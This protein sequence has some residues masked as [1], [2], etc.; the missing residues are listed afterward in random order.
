MGPPEKIK[1]PI[2]NW[3]GL[4]GESLGS[5][6]SLRL[7]SIHK[8]RAPIPCMGTNALHFGTTL[9]IFSKQLALTHLRDKQLQ[10][11]RKQNHMESKFMSE[12]FPLTLVKI[13][14]NLH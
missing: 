8:G 5:W 3:R 12:K 7:P 2:H 13:K 9:I 14:G 1:W 4:E 11:I 10:K 6:S